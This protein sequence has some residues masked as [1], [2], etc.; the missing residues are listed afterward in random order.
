MRVVRTV[1]ELLTLPQ[2]RFVNGFR[3]RAPLLLDIPEVSRPMLIRAQ[4]ALNRLQQ[5]G[6]SLAGAAVMFIAMLAG[7]SKVVHENDSL[8]SWAAVG[9]L[10]LVLAISFALGV[11]AKW[12]TLA[13]TRLQ[14]AYRCRVQHDLLS[15]LLPR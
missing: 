1:D 5:R 2:D 14:F 4:D 7:V 12:A 8:L 11:A 10:I 15:M 13:I 9:E 3:G 6:G